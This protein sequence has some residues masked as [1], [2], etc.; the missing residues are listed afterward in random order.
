LLLTIHHI[1]TDATSAGILLK[2]LL[3]CYHGEVTGVPVSLPPL[4]VSYA[5]YVHWETE[6]LSGTQGERL[7]TYWHQQLAGEIPILHLPTDHPRPPV[8]TYNGASHRFQWTA[9]LSQSLKTLAQEHE[10]TVFAV[11]LSAFQILLHRYTGQ[12]EIW[13][14]LPVTIG[15][16]T[17]FAKVVGYLVNTVV[18]R[19]NFEQPTLTFNQ[20]LS[21]SWQTLL[22]ALEHQDYPLP[23]LVKVLSPQRDASYTPL[24]QVMFNF[25]STELINRSSLSPSDNLTVTV[26][27]LDQQE[28][29]F[30]LSLVI[31]ERETL[32]GSF[33]Y[34]RDLFEPATIAR[35]AGHLETLLQG[36]V[37]NPDQ[38]IYQLPLLTAPELQQ[39][40]A[41]ND[42]AVDYPQD[43][44]IVDLFEQQVARTP[45]HIA[46]VFEDQHLT[47]Q[48]L[49]DQ[50]NQLAHYLL[51]RQTQAG[52]HL[53]NPLIAIAVERSVEM[54]IGLLGILK[55]GG[56]YMPIDPSY[57]RERLRYLLE[58]SAAPLLLT[59]S[60]LQAQLPTLEHDCVVVCLDEAKWA[61]QPTAKPDVKSQAG[62]LAYV[63]YTSG[64]TG[65]PKGVMVEHQALV[66]HMCWMQDLLVFTTADKVL[67][68]TPF[69]FDASVWEFYAPLLSG[70][71]LILAKPRP[72]IDLKEM[73]ILLKQAQVTVLQ[74]VPSLLAALLIEAKTVPNGLR[75]LFCGGEAL[76]LTTQ[77][78]FYENRTHTKLYN[79]YGPTEA[80]IDATCWES[81]AL[82]DISIGK[83]IANTR[84]YIL[85]AQHQPQPPRLARRTVHC[86]AWSGPWLPPSSRTHRRQIH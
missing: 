28:G 35:L 1:F 32:G 12:P 72:V 16:Q 26:F 54:V 76:S 55:A 73:L 53:H 17:Q 4:S 7:A 51:A 84:I 9:S 47:Y 11:L 38:S 57:P 56:A 86:R 40:Q 29:L 74:L 46:L 14:G 8:Q 42:T 81:R 49:N 45:N 31:I 10:T 62:D 24:F 27:E 64:S 2:E 44:T 60:H 3:K 82:A 21:Q 61:D 83:P 63:I 85:D 37:A 19:A 71:S 30:D 33:R 5:D 65:K 15:R 59:Q 6:M 36:L 25:E 80:C 43:L 77:Q 58:D 13:I 18:L 20:L 41:W 79:L 34:N 50:A 68:K 78:K 39:L 67:Q 66:N 70:G 23:I 22:D 52:I 75:Y 48:Q 69:S